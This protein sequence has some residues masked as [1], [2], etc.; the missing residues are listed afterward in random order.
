MLRLCAVLL[1]LKHPSLSLWAEHGASTVDEAPRNRTRGGSPTPS[2]PYPPEGN[3]AAA[4]AGSSPPGAHSP[5]APPTP[6]AAAA[7]RGNASAGGG[8]IVGKIVRLPVAVV[9][10]GFGLAFYTVCM[11]VS[12]AAL[13][14]DRVLPA[15]VM[16]GVR[17]GCCEERVIKGGI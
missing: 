3:A 10:V 5:V 17:G 8:G 15:G 9:R 7:V 2:S 16:R 4:T 14:A 13:V 11:A 12:V 1:F 6:A